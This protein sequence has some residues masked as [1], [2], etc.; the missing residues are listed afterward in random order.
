MV[1]CL[2][3]EWVGVL[4]VPGAS[5]TAVSKHFFRKGS[6]FNS[7][8]SLVISSTSFIEAPCMRYLWVETIVELAFFSM[9]L[10]YTECS[11]PVQ[12]I[13]N[14][15][16]LHSTHQHIGIEARKLA[17]YRWLAEGRS[18]CLLAGFDWRAAHLLPFHCMSH[19]ASSTLNVCSNVLCPWRNSRVGAR[20]HCLS[21]LPWLTCQNLSSTMLRIG[22]LSGS[23]ISSTCK[24]FWWTLGNKL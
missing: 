13:Q 19:F 20:S 17:E 3:S 1:P 15:C 14:S 8:A 9:H 5:K 11:S 22:Q 23:T 10:L 4:E 24:L 7:C 6:S 12:R 21:L 16:C 18:S 2:K